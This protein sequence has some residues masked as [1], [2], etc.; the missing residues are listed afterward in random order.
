MHVLQTF[1]SIST[2]P[3]RF[4]IGLHVYPSFL[5]RRIWRFIHTF[6][7]TIKVIWNFKLKVKW[8]I[9]FIITRWLGFIIKLIY[10][11]SRKFY[12]LSKLRRSL[13]FFNGLL[14]VNNSTICFSCAV[15]P[16]WKSGNRKM[17]GSVIEMNYIVH[18]IHVLNIHASLLIVY[19]GDNQ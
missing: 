9:C 7:A 6:Y 3:V 18:I 19:K 8:I 15:N 17:H 16:G 1:C 2:C 11:F 10:F 13:R 5:S 14:P 4:E 12:N